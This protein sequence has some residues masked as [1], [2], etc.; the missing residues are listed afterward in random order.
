MLFYVAGLYFISLRLRPKSLLGAKIPKHI[1]FWPPT[2]MCVREK[3]KK[4][5]MY[6]T[7]LF[8]V[9]VDCVWDGVR[10]EDELRAPG[11][12]GGQHPGGGQPGVQGG[13]LRPGP[14]H[15]GQRVHGPPG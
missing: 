11:P 5:L 3:T 1:F 12:A 13:R 9:A 6:M 7:K 14:A 8:C 10:G 2:A 15:R 4:S